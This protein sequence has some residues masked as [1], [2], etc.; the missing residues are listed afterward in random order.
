MSCPGLVKAKSVE[1]K[2]SNLAAEADGSVRR[3]IQ[4]IVNCET[5]VTLHEVDGETR[6]FLFDAELEGVRVIM[7]RPRQISERPHV[8]LSPREREIARMVAKGYPNK[9]IAAVLDISSWTVCTYRRRI[10]AKLNVCSRAAMVARLI[11]EGLLA[12][13]STAEPPPLPR[14]R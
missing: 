1:S 12:D 14:R 7:S 13:K 10:F 9:T 5:D 4:A 6:E 11:E 3:W 2:G 8:L